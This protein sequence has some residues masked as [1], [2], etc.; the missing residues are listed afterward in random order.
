MVAAIWLASL[1]RHLYTDRER[2]ALL[3]SVSVVAI[4][5]FIVMWA[6]GYFMIGSNF[7]PEGWNYV[8]RWQPLS[9]VDSGTEN[10]TGW[11]N[12]LDDRGELAGESEAFSFLGI[13]V[14]F[15]MAISLT[16]FTHKYRKTK[17]LYM[18]STLVG[19]ALL[20]VYITHS[21]SVSR[22]VSIGAL[23]VVAVFS[24][25]I[26]FHI[27]FLS[28]SWRE[29]VP[30]LITVCMLAIYSMTN[31]VGFAQQTFFEYPLFPPLEQFTES[32]RTHGRS[33]WPL[34]YILTI[35]VI[36][37]TS[38]SFQ[39]RTATIL[40]VTFLM[41][42]L[43]DSAPAIKL[44]RARF[45]NVNH[46]VSPMKSP[47]WELLANR[48]ENFVVVP[49]LNDDVEE[50]WVV[51]DEFVSKYQMS[52][53]SGSFSRFDQDLHQKITNDLVVDLLSGNLDHNA[54]Y[55]IIDNHVWTEFTE[56]NVSKPILVLDG[57]RLV[58]P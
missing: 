20:F 18:I 27:C 40:F 23:L 50:K 17:C 32:F 56:A 46:W 48:Y 10:S 57:F 35:G 55:L 37:Y 29:Y 33:I 8:F 21:N 44:A 45:I 41:I 52:T 15:L 54:L 49:P 58:V 5:S 4:T 11:S 36:V 14:I 16:Q 1:V 30:L 31:R 43:I 34:F 12:L 26:L 53:N 6:S 47:Y 13:S 38:R 42:Q 19:V 28:R 2:F 25:V 39:S 3:K 51:I 24:I 22:V 7:N 9:L